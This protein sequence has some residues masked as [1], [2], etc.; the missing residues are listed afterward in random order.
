MMTAKFILSLEAAH[1]V[2][3]TALDSIVCSTGSMMSQMLQKLSMRILSIE[4]IEGFRDNI[5]GVFSQSNEIECFK[6]LQIHQSRHTFYKEHFLLIP[7]EK[8]LFGSKYVKCWGGGNRAK[9]H[10]KMWILYSIVK[11]VTN[12]N[13]TS[14]ICSIH[15]N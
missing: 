7:P 6:D 1:K 12:V 13:E 4:G 5:Q 8:C 10:K 2:S 3:S 14:P 11:N 9:T 15:T